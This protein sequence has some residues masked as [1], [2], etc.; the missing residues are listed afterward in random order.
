VIQHA[1]RVPPCTFQ[2]PQGKQRHADQTVTDCPIRRIGRFRRIGAK[3]FSRRQ[4]RPIA[5]PCVAVAKQAPKRSQA[6]IR[7]VEASAIS[8]ALVKAAEVSGDEPFITKSAA[9]SAAFNCILRRAFRLAAGPES[10]RSTRPRHSS[11]SDK[12]IHSGTAATVSATP[13]SASP[14][15]EKANPGPR[16]LSNLMAIAHQPHGAGNVSNSIS[17]L[18]QW[19][20]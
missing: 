20:R 1:L 19:S 13:T 8:K 2:I 15:G 9:P 16:D 4:R 7:I 6:I 12:Y 10:A 17:A 5:A 18:S 14:V 3:A 11:I